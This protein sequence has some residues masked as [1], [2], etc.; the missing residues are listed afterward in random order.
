MAPD[1][2]YETSDEIELC[3]TQ[4]LYLTPVQR[5][6]IRVMLPESQDALTFSNQDIIDQLK[7]AVSPDQFSNIRI[8]ESAK[9]FILLEG[10]AE[11]KGLAQAFLAKLHGSGIKFDG[12]TEDLRVEVT[13]DQIHFP[14]KQ[15][16]EASLQATKELKETEEFREGQKQDIPSSLHVRGLP[17]QWFL[18]ADSNGGKPSMEVL[19]KV[20]E[21][22]GT[23]KNIDIPMLESRGEEVSGEGCD[24]ATSGLLDTFEAFIQY[25]DSK[26]LVKATESLRGMQLMFKGED[27][28]GVP[29]KMKVMVDTTNHF[30]EE[31]TNQ[32][33]LE[34]LKLLEKQQNEENKEE[35]DERKGNDEERNA[36]EEPQ[37]TEKEWEA[38]Q[39]KGPEETASAAVCQPDVEDLWLDG[40]AEWEERKL[41]LAQRRVESMKLLTT[42][43]EKVQEYVILDNFSKELLLNITVDQD[44]CQSTKVKSVKK[45]ERI[46]E[47][48]LSDE[49]DWEENSEIHSPTEG[50][51][52]IYK[53]EAWEE[54]KED[55]EKRD[56]S[57]EDKSYLS[58][59]SSVSP[60][61]L[62]ITT[63]SEETER[64]SPER[65]LARAGQR[66]RSYRSGSLQMAMYK[67]NHQTET[68]ASGGNWHSYSGC[69]SVATNEAVC[70]KKPKIYETDEFIHYLLNY[71]EYP[72]YARV[73]LEQNNTESD[74]WWQRVVFNNGSGFQISLMNLCG[75]PYSRMTAAPSTKQQPPKLKNK[76][77]Y[78][79]P[80][81]EHL[82]ARNSCPTLTKD[83]HMKQV[84]A[85]N[86]LACV[87][88]RNTPFKKPNV[89]P[90]GSCKAW[91]KKTP[92]SYQQADEASELK[93]LLEKISS[94][95]E[96]FSEELENFERK[97]K[98]VCTEDCKV[99]CKKVPIKKQTIC[100]K[101]R[102]IS[103]FPN[104]G[105][106]H[107][108]SSTVAKDRSP[109]LMFLNPRLQG[110]GMQEARR[111]VKFE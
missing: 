44:S 61:D 66:K 39:E 84:H 16:W 51:D 81:S 56:E 92:M 111:R 70:Y 102:R 35:K 20:F 75:Q 58:I 57:K 18:S 98:R 69:G 60:Y 36:H 45:A 31:V 96:Y 23:V 95:S 30:S 21:T 43:L 110:S 88:Q 103:M 97:P 59:S 2:V 11:T 67:N 40:T 99:E 83:L 9:E 47:I 68:E 7:Q 87:K 4:S 5:L 93:D 85:K 22:F 80:N 101:R 17:C 86:K 64:Q 107:F 1:I 15:S 71:Y 26:S 63:S 29:C 54:E 78:T 33:N 91:Q 90:L 82:L 14:S 77:R 106:E 74:A 79:V 34:K 27:G 49:L 105:I 94:D 100:P 28:K 37:E 73:C 76:W 6:T 10:E 12:L 89:K 108:R 24:S 53:G 72:A 38:E 48:V 25:G 46:S 42:L 13:E 62:S 19:K 41:V 65:I 50:N 3:A 55:A 104:T 52:S 8:S 109:S 32:R